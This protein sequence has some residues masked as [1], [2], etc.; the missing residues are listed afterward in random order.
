MNDEVYFCKVIHKLIL[1]CSACIGR[2]AQSTQNKK[3][4]YLCNISRKTWKMKL[5]FCFLINIK[6]FCK[7]IVSHW[8]CIA[9]HAQSTQKISLQYLKENVKDEIDF[10]PV[11]KHQRFLQ[12]DTIILDLCGQASPNYPK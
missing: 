8:V 12:I 11:D 5:I 2:H 4:L 3:F 10:L 6:V 9:R 1:S 7:M